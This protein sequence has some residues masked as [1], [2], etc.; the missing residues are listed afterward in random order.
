MLH[1][2][3]DVPDVLG[4]DVRV[5]GARADELGEGGEQTLDANARHRDVLA[6][7]QG[8]EEGEAV[9]GGDEVSACVR[10]SLG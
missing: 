8:C 2:G 10:K 3:V 6:R 1:R 5:L 9:G 4:L 7:Y